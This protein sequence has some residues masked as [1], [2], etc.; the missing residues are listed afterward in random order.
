VDVNVVMH[1]QTPCATALA[2]R[3]ADNINYYVIPEIPFYIGP[4]AGVPYLLPGSKEL[5]DAVTNAMQNHD[6]VMMKN[7]G[8]VTAAPDYEHAIQ[9]AEFFE[10]ACRIIVCNGDSVMPLSEEDIE[11]LLRLR[12]DARRSVFGRFC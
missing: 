12:Q 8:M 1:F 6:M 9:N 4:V 5:A 11:C 2:C 10:L 3:H 7:H